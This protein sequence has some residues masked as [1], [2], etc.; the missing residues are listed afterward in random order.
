[1]TDTMNTE[2]SFGSFLR[3][4]YA[5]MFL[6]LLLTAITA[7]VVSTNQSLAQ[8]VIGNS[9]V[10]YGLMVVE[11]ILVFVLASRVR[12]MS[13]STATFLFLLYSVLNGAT[14]ASIFLAYTG[15][16]IV[17]AFAG[18]AVMFGVVSLYGSIT[19]KDLTGLGHFMGMALIGLIVVSLID[20]F[21]AS[22][23]LDWITSWAGVVIFTAL[24]AYDTQK[25]KRLY[26][27]MD[28]KADER[29]ASVMGALTLYL[30]FINLF[31][32]LLRI[33]GRQRSD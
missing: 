15:A 31:L 30:D 9:F 33:F 3:G 29:S 6:G 19:K 4:V 23:A 18:T 16:S 1:M 22:Q 24:T 10:F 11:L 5:W 7:F 20:I 14:F 32:D 17:L 8:I 27:S 26:G 2:N 12:S 28:S 21:F 13:S 25:M